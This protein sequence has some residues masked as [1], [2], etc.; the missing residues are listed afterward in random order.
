MADQNKS[1]GIKK[2][3]VIGAGVMGAGIAAQVA[4]GGTPVLLLD[5]VKVGEADRDAVAKGAVAKLLKTDPA[6]FMSKAAAKLVETGN[7]E[8][9]LERIAE[10][11]W[12]VEAI[13]ERLD[14]KQS[15]YKRIDAE[16]KPG[17]AISS[18]TSTIPLGQLVEGLPDSFQRDF[19]ITHFFNP[20]RYMRLLEI[21]TGPKTDAALAAKVGSFCDL[22]LGKTVV[23]AKDTPGF[24]ANRIGTYWMQQAVNQAMDLGLTVEEADAV[25]G[26]PLGFPK[27]GVFGLLD[28]VGLDLMPHINASMKA[29]LPPGDAFHATNRDV[30]LIAKMITDGY[31]GRKG[32]GGFY[33][34]NK[35]A[36]KVKE[37]IGLTTGEYAP[38]KPVTLPS[39]LAKDARALLASDDKLGQF[40]W[41]TMAPTLA[42][43]AS[44]VPEISDDI[45][46]ADTAMKLG[47]NW[48]FGPFELLD[49]LGPKAVA[50]RLEKDGAAVPDLLRKLGEGTFYKIEAG[51]RLFFGTDG[52]YHEVKVPEGVLKLEDVK[53]VSQPL[54]KSG[55][56]AAWD[57]GDGVVCF[58]FTGKMNA[59]D[60]GVI[61]LLGKTLS[62]V[63]AKHK[64]LVVYTD[65]DNFSVGANL[66]LALF[67]AN[68]AAW[69]EIERSIS[70]GQ[71]AYKAL[72]YAPFPVVAAP[73]GMALGG[74][75]EICLHSDAIQAHAE[76]YMGLVECGVGVIPGWGGCGE[77]IDRWKSA[78]GMPKGPMP[79]VTK[80]FETISTA[81]VSKSAAEA[82]ELMFLRPT[83][84]IT[85]NRDRL[86]ADAKAKALAL[87]ENYAPPPKPEFRLPSAGGKTAMDMAVDGFHK[88]GK[89]TDHDVT[90]ADALATV[91]SGGDY[92]LVDVVTEQQVLDLERAAFL[93]LLK[94][95]Q[96]LARVE[97]MLETG[98]PLRN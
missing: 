25:L 48:K 64:A 68:I 3:C 80:V 27:T 20:P 96:T 78:P 97:H 60:E 24:I 31:T 22:T 10:C 76:T 63:K 75:C 2:V 93:R 47:F 52:Q 9:H 46:G 90:V 67:A 15:L 35:A 92:D 88:Q 32:K 11:D 91:L 1:E 84:G 30:P 49:K 57:I 18:N 19:L 81:T 14:L 8:D 44:L 87:V 38:S 28:L 37:S 58:E 5:I 29:T 65:A 40:A 69:G 6:A 66:G 39:A 83:D 7:I 61:G 53:R 36:G 21:V 51:K 13:I 23:R 42:Y 70:G 16:R 55:S 54:L 82:K 45:V 77:M 94:T 79:A 74:G 34:L 4:N 17:T 72:K 56:A 43:A 89:A 33:R 86:L 73:A 95:P 59:L 85:M 62:L 12:V 50:E 71:Q 26:K 41:K 98:K